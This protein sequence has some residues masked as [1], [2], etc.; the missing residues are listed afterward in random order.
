MTDNKPL[1]PTSAHSVAT[2]ESFLRAVCD[3]DFD[4]VAALSDRNLV[5][6]N[7]GLPTL[8]GRDRI[9]RFMRAGEGQLVIDMKIHRI[10]ADGDTVLVER[11][12]AWIV[13]RVRMQLW[14]CS[15][16]EL[17]DGRV[18]LWRD[19]FDYLAWARAIARGL[20]GALVPALQ[21][22]F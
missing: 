18:A 19:Y 11:T 20:A 7:V 14:V 6:Q 12:D 3:D 16:L 15:V 22:K 1:R 4:A 21:K 2:V 9:V 10:A 8:R 13:G 17:R 5:W